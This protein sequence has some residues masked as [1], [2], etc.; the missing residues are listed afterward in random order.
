MKQIWRVARREVK[1]Y[2]DHP[3][4]YILLIAF[5]LLA[6]FVAFRTL[7]GSGTASLRTVFLLL[8]WLFAVFIPAMTMRAFA[9]ER[10]SGTLDW[11]SSQPL[12]EL[13]L[14]LGKL[15]GN[16]LFV[17]TTLIGTLPTAIGV[18]LLSDA[19]PG[20]MIAQYLGAVLLAAQMT[21]IGVWASSATRNQV[22]AF[23]L[24]LAV[25]WS[26][27]FLGEP[28]LLT[29]L[30]D[31]VAVWASNLSI[32]THF[33]PVARGAL[34]LRD[35]LYFASTALLF[36]TFAC[37]ILVRRRLSKVRGGPRRLQLGT[38][39]IVAAVIAVNAAGSGL[40]QRFDLTSQGLYSLSDA[41]RDV[42]RS[43]DDQV[44]IKLFASRALPPD[45]QRTVRD[46]RDLL[47]DFRAASGGRGCTTGR[48]PQA[49][50]QAGEE[51]APDGPRPPPFRPP[52]SGR[53][54][55]FRRPRHARRRRTAKPRP[56]SRR[57]R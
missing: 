42:L 7:Y 40:R 37:G 57:S 24:G 32:L 17:L 43:L 3:T 33:E 28:V 56:P 27:V 16:L 35:L 49:R 19:D 10:R 13:D 47:G 52:R 53:S 34:D 6:L 4:A 8:P 23:I 15:L 38:A 41:T 55:G 11:L 25:S 22:T 1:G 2:F 9:E 14:L 31:R 21:A 30:P 39:A 18:L 36:G 50:P 20:I 5:L 51:A 26:L 46:I 48:P 12:S 54:S 44:T 45:V 29:A